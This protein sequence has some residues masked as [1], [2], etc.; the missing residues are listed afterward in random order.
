MP[1]E[2]FTPPFK[3]KEALRDTRR[4]SEDW[5]QPGEVPGM[6]IKQTASQSTATATVQTFQ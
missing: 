1:A 4:I 6:E 3:L 5:E 2:M